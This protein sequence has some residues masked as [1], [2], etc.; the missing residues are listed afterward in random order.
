VLTCDLDDERDVEDA[1]EPRGEHEWDQVTHVHRVAAR[2]PSGVEVER[3]S[4][5]VPIE[6]DVEVADEPS[7]SACSRNRRDRRDRRGRFERLDSPVG[8]ECASTKQR[9][10]SISRDILKT[11][12]EVLR[13]LLGAKPRDELVVIAMYSAGSSNCAH[14][15]SEILALL[16]NRA[17]NIERRDLLLLRGVVLHHQVLLLWDQRGPHPGWFSTPSARGPLSYSLSSQLAE[18]TLSRHFA[19]GSSEPAL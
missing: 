10:G 17:L 8:E 2:S 15:H 3:L 13:D 9:V 6:N 5:L 12:E 11:V 16:V 7:V 19:N 1:L 4:L 18:L 14:S